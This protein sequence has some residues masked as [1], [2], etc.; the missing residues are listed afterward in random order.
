MP[1]KIAILVTV[2]AA[3][4]LLAACSLFQ[5]NPEKKPG[6]G[7]EESSDL[8]RL[9]PGTWKIMAVKCDSTGSN[10]EQYAASRMFEFSAGGEFT[11]NGTVRGAYRLEGRNLILDT[12]TKHYTVTI[13]QIGTYRMVTGESSRNTTE[14]FNRIK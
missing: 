14:V 4:T 5:A 8:T 2:L 7:P 11:V 6:P 3:S 10:C 9:I 13:V 12:D 1:R